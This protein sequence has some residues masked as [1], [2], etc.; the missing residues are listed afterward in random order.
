MLG[1]AYVTVAR[2]IVGAAGL[3]TTPSRLALALLRGYRSKAIMP[4]PDDHRAIR[5][6]ETAAPQSQGPKPTHFARSPQ[7]VAARGYSNLL[8]LRQRPK[9]DRG[10]R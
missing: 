3:V 9:L 7:T 10:Q 6:A 5:L 1:V 8:N 2:L 4:Q